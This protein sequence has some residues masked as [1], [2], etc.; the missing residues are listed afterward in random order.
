MK[1]KHYFL[2]A[3]L[4]SML[5]FTTAVQAQAPDTLWTRT[6]GGEGEDWFYSMVV[7]ADSCFMLAGNTSSYGAGGRDFWLVKTDVNGDTLWTR[8][9][10]GI[11]D[12]Y[13]GDIIETSD[14][15]YALVGYTTSYSNGQTDIW[16]VK[17]DSDGIVLWSEN[18]GADGYEFAF[19]IVQTYDDGYAIAGEFNHAAPSQGEFWVLKVSSSGDSLWSFLYHDSPTYETSKAIIETS[20]NEIIAAGYPGRIVK[21]NSEGIPIWNYTYGVIEFRDMINTFEGNYAA[22][23]YGSGE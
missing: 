11:G 18:Y 14:S 22:L 19:K 6:Y 10:G 23:G 21:L 3:A 17:I 12:D 15:G 20:A 9:Y 16:L 7:T 8:T 13:C 5:L 4:T 2:L 1:T